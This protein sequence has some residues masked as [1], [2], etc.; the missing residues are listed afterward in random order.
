M[1]HTCRACAGPVRADTPTCPHC[2]ALNPVGGETTSQP[3]QSSGFEI[4]RRRRREAAPEVEPWQAHFQRALELIGEQQFA[5]A[6]GE[7]SQAIV[8][9]P[10]HEIAKCYATRGYAQLC[11]GQYAPAVEDCSLA[12]GHDATD[13]EA[14]AWR[15]SA[16]AA[17]HQ[18]RAAL[19]DYAQAIQLAPDSAEEYHTIAVQHAGRAIVELIEFERQ[20]RISP[21]L[22]HD[23]AVAYAFRG[24]HEPAIRDFTSAIRLE[25]RDVTSYHKRAECHAALQHHDRVLADCKAAISL[26]DRSA[27]IYFLRGIANA[28]T[29]HRE[30]AI[31]DFNRTLELAPQHVTAIFERGQLHESLGEAAAALGDYALAI[32]LAPHLS[33]HHLARARLH[34]ALQQPAAAVEDYSQALA[35][36]PDDTSIL[37]ARGE[38]LVAINRED[39]ALAD[40]DTAIRTDA[41]C[42]P[43]FRGR[44][45]IFIKRGQPD[46]AIAELSKAIRLN[47]RYAPAY[48]SRG[49]VFL[50]QQRYDQA[51]ADLSKAIELETQ[52]LVLA[53]LHYRRGLAYL[54]VGKPDKAAADFDRSL[55]L[56]P[57]QPD[58]LAWR[59]SARGH[60]Q[61]W[62]AAIDDLQQAIAMN[63]S[64][65][66][67]YTQLADACAQAAI[68]DLDARL[69]TQPDVAAWL[70]DRAVAHDFRGAPQA[71]LQDYN[72]AIKLEPL[73]AEG[74]L[75][76][77]KLL[78]RN[79]KH[80]LAA[81]DFSRVIKLNAQASA[82]WHGRGLARRQLGKL[83]EAL[84][85][86]NQA[87]TLGGEQARLR[88]DRGML[89]AQ[90]GRHED[91]IVE[92]SKSLSIDPSSPETYF[93]R[94]L[95]AVALSR[96]DQAIADLDH[97]IAAQPQ[98]VKA[99][100]QRAEA[101]VQTKRWKKA[102]AD[103]EAVIA[104]DPGYVQ[105][106]CN[107][108]F[109]LARIG[110]QEQALLELSKALPRIK[111]DPAFAAVLGIRARVYY[112]VSLFQHA[113]ADYTHLL[114]LKPPGQNLAAAFHGRALALYQLGNLSAAE[115]NLLKSLEA[116]PN[117][118]PAHNALAWLRSDR[119]QP[120]PHE[121]KSPEA[122]LIW[123][124]PPVVG[125]P[126]IVDATKS[127][128]WQT[129]PLW[130]QWIVRLPDGTEYGPRCKADL[131]VWCAQGRLHPSYWL[132][133]LDGEQWIGAGD[134]YFELTFET[135]RSTNRPI[136]VS[137][138]PEEPV[139]EVAAVE[140]VAEVEA[141]GPGEV[142][143]EG[144]TAEEV[145]PN[146]FA[147]IVTQPGIKPRR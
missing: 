1:F 131:D 130:D 10:D 59:G 68:T 29:G 84:A 121:F 61:Q 98:H 119:Q 16:Y 103:Y 30:P 72:G 42:A 28:R 21:Q 46:A 49:E 5:P 86:L 76:R 43:G 65:A 71:A 145:E 32:E 101:H 31:A 9:A 144:A 120:A 91:A 38:A 2:G 50:A 25:Q 22:Y 104:I 102:L 128:A 94:A 20:R 27:E 18:W 127:A 51:I 44:G 81:Q 56:N 114:H 129:E 37:L 97:V 41:T 55:T 23:R 112:S 138:I 118:K 69:A 99:I 85:D 73:Q 8:D 108:G 7:L 45:L 13:G 140:E 135:H 63:P 126:V 95:A 35:L 58:A 67:L 96:F 78:A 57:Q 100:F 109:T 141:V 139:E 113:A 34:A 80:D 125:Q 12:I 132:L 39:E 137:V 133:R 36:L 17:L 123:R 107:R 60:L 62:R 124:K 110:K 116:N 117:F 74:Y 15:G 24:E 64:G 53:G 146:P 92:Y 54:D 142:P 75:R 79:H 70:L 122:K 26:G 4:G 33:Q 143:A 93:E 77:A 105:A 66:E 14:F 82:A 6:L 87:V 89:L 48:A 88:H 83:D 52:P 40:F 11:L 3:A 115:K 47:T 90:L 147:F 19:D 136:P 134:V 106:Y 111:H